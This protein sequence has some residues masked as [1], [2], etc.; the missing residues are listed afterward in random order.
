MVEYDLVNVPIVDIVNQI[1]LYAAQHRTSDIH[2]DPREDSLMIRMRIDGELRNHTNI[3]KAYERNLI[4]RVK[5]ISN[6]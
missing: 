1:I 3:P 5:L 4:T 2:M 6:P